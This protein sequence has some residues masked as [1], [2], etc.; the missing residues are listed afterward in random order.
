MTGKSKPM[1]S[2]EGWEYLDG[3]EKGGC[4]QVTGSTHIK[5]QQKEWEGCL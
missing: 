3:Q 4:Y 2:F 1:L 5:S